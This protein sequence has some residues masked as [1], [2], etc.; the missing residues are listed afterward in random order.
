VFLPK[1]L[2]P[3]CCESWAA[4][5][6]LATLFIEENA[7]A[8]VAIAAEEAA[9]EAW[10]EFFGERGTI[11]GVLISIAISGDEASDSR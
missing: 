2:I 5:A 11:L 1:P 8:M 7:A 9:E 10:S 3:K 6:L 4:R